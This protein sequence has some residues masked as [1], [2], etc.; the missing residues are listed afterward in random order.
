MSPGT[1]AAQSSGVT[2]YESTWNNSDCCR[3]RIFCRSAIL[4][5]PILGRGVVDAASNRSFVWVALRHSTLYGYRNGHGAGASSGCSISM[6]DGGS[7]R[8]LARLLK[9]PVILV[10]FG[11]IVQRLMV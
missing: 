3:R 6:P 8:P 9:P 5:R 2:C 1:G 10:C 4:L 7:A 11:A